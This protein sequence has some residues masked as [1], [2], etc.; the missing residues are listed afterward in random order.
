MSTTSGKAIAKGTEAPAQEIRTGQGSSE[1]AAA[2]IR[3][4]GQFV[5]VTAAMWAEVLSGK[6]TPQVANAA[7][8]AAKTMLAAV[9]LQCRYGRNSTDG[10]R[11]RIDLFNGV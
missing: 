6:L 1:L 7:T 11:E 8:N 5:S 2:G 10:T 9:E 3:T 4:V